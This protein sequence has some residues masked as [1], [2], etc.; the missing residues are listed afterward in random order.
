M[1]QIILTVFLGATAMSN[2]QVV[3]GNATGTAAVK[4]SVLLEFPANENK[5]LILPYVRTLP[6][7]PAEGTMLLDATDPTKAR[8]KYYNGAWVDLSGQDSN[9][10]SALAAQ[11]TAAQ[12]PETPSAKVVIGASSSTAN[13]VLV[14]E[15][16]TR[17]MVLPIVADVQ[18][19]QNPSPGMMVY[20]NKAGA[21]R[22]AVFNGSKWSY[23]KS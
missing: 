1:K 20:V 23:W 15:S 22:L 10:T 19:I 13:G 4:T 18:N 16:T 7:A 21:K 6:A 2:A 11:P 14:L 12:T 3:I 5:G 9:V 17:S 8:I